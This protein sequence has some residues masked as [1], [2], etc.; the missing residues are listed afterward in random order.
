MTMSH[1]PTAPQALFTTEMIKAAVM[2]E[3]AEAR[4]KAAICPQCQV[5]RLRQVGGG[6]GLAFWQ[7]GHCNA[8]VCFSA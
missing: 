5:K 4:A 1:E 2:T 6:A 8:V 7:C 3:L